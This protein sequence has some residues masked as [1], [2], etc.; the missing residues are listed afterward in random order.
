MD[1]THGTKTCVICGRAPGCVNDRCNH[2]PSYGKTPEPLG[3]LGPCPTCGKIACPDCEHEAD[4]CF[5]LA[6][7]HR[8]ES[9][10]APHGWEHVGKNAHGGDEYK[11]SEQ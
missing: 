8:S 11:R 9:G 2:P 10:W 5:E 1:M 3:D 4:C 6:D 7:D